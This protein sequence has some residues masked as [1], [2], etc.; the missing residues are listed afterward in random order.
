MSDLHL[1]MHAWSNQ[2]EMI[3]TSVESVDMFD[4]SATAVDCP[5]AEFRLI[6]ASLYHVLHRTTANEPLRK[7]QQTKGQKGFEAWHAIVRRYDQ[8]NMSDTKSAYAD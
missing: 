4:S 8:R 2:G 3:L 7:V 5:D 1:W 6:E